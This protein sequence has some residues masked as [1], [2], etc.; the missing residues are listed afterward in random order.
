MSEPVKPVLDPIVVSGGLAVYLSQSARGE[1]VMGGEIDAYPC[2]SSRSS[3]DI[4]EDMMGPMLE[5]FPFLAGMKLLRQWGGI[6]DVTDDYSPIMGPSPVDDYFLSAG[7]G[8]M[9]FKAIPAGGYG[10]AELVATGRAPDLIGPFGLER[11]STLS[12]VGERAA[13]AVGH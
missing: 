4:K 11:F 6:A 5:L 12:L 1:F 10:M 3:P 8:T 2:V 13:A 9:G 7:W